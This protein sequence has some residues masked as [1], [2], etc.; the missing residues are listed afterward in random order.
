MNHDTE[1]AKRTEL[2]EDFWDQYNENHGLE[3]VMGY[4]VHDVDTWKDSP[5]YKKY[6]KKIY[7]VDFADSKE[8]LHNNRPCIE[9]SFKKILF[10]LTLAGIFLTIRAA[11][12]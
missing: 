9:F 7:D 3:G 2:S 5:E 6:C 11:N 12:E 4:E 8:C 10:G 1:N